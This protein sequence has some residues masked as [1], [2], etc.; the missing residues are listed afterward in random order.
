MLILSLSLIKGRQPVKYNFC[1][2]SDFS[3][4]LAEKG[5]IVLNEQSS[6][7][8]ANM[9]QWVLMATVLLL[10]SVSYSSI[11]MSYVSYFSALGAI[12]VGFFCYIIVAAIGHDAAHKSVSKINFVNRFAVFFSF[13]LIGVSGALWAKRH[14]RIHHQVPN[15]V[16][17]EIDGDGSAVLRFHEGQEWKPWHRFQPIYA[18]MLYLIVL[19]YT[20]WVDDFAFLKKELSHTNKKTTVILEFIATKILHI[21]LAVVLPLLYFNARPEM[22]LVCYLI[23]TMSASFLFVIF[24]IGTHINIHS[25]IINAD[26]DNNLDHDWAM[27]QVKTTVNWSPENKIAGLLTGGVNAHVTHH[28][29]PYAAHCHNTKLAK[30]VNRV[31]VKHAVTLNVI[32]FKEMIKGHFSLIKQLAKPA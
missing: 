15:V 26:L 5:K 19:L 8:Y 31:S 1:R 13:T 30:L 29:F 7:R 6:G 20:A 4:E 23:A 28:L 3:K 18:P 11:I 24:N 16:G 21:I 2:S 9:S 27:H 14:I 25:K 12:I 10:F 17:N 22:V 32:S